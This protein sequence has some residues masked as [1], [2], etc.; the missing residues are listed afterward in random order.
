MLIYLRVNCL[1]FFFFFS[2]RRR[3]TRL[4]CDWSSDV[5]S[6]DLSTY[7]DDEKNVGW[8][9]VESTAE[10]IRSKGRRALT[11]TGDVSRAEP[12][13]QLVDLIVKTL[14]RLDVL[15][16]NAAYP[17]GNDRVPLPALDEVEWRKA[18]VIKL[19]GAFVRGKRI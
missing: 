3:H 19:T 8:R 13:G 9:D 10:Q 14:G 4:T 11:W 18:L 7:P 6:S 12:V 15:V 17:R 16:N 2:S 1:G 5:C